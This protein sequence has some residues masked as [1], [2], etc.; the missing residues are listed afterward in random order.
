VSPFDGVKHRTVA[1]TSAQVRR[2]TK[3][4]IEFA[5]RLLVEAG[6]SVAPGVGITMRS[7]SAFG[8]AISLSRMRGR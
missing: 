8:A 7:A 3:D 4:S 6:V 5:R 1:R 2:F